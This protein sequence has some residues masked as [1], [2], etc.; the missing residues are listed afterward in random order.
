MSSSNTL[1]ALTTVGKIERK[2]ICVN[3]DK[4]KIEKV[5]TT[6]QVGT[7]LSWSSFSDQKRASEAR[8]SIRMPTRAGETC[9]V[10]TMS[11]QLS[12]HGLASVQLSHVNSS[13]PR[14]GTCPTISGILKRRLLNKLDLQ[15]V[16]CTSRKVPVHK[17]H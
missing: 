10:L 4:H 7:F 2:K 5:G 14:S 1:V 16:F 8:G 11:K 12:S 13:R 3:C 9:R 6:A 17:K 15:N